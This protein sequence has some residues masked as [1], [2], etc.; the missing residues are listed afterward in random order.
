MAAVSKNAIDNISDLVNKSKKKKI[1]NDTLDQDYYI[2]SDLWYEDSIETTNTS[3]IL[4]SDT[5]MFQNLN[6]SKKK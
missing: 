4:Q 6:D 2:A 3:L 1:G 5:S